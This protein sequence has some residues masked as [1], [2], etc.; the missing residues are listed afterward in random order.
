MA[1]IETDIALQPLQAGEI[2][3]AN[4][5]VAIRARLNK[6][7]SPEWAKLFASA[8]VASKNALFANAG[9]SLEEDRIRYL[10][11]TDAISERKHD[12]VHQFVA[13]ANRLAA[14]HNAKEDAE[15]KARAEQYQTDKAAFDAFQKRMIGK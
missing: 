3:H 7:P 2:Q 10:T 9:L 1:H 8:V 5:V 14:E 6:V 12:F 13:E 15:N 4:G 11:G